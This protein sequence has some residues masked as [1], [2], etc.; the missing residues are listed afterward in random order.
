M[1][2]TCILLL[3][4]SIAACGGKGDGTA[5]DKVDPTVNLRR[6]QLATET[7]PE[8]FKVRFETTA[9]TF[10]I[11]AVREWSPNGVDRFYNLAR[12]GFF[13]DVTF[14][15]VISGFMAQFGINGDPQVSSVWRPR[16][17]EDDPVKQSNLRGYVTFAKTGQPNSRSTQLF[18]NFADNIRLDGMGFSPIGKVVEGMDVVDRVYAGYGE[19]P[20]RGKGPNQSRVQRQGNLYLRQEFPKLD[21]IKKA[22]LID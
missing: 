10:V 21:Y 12:V 2:R 3:L 13:D 18:I 17:I 14:F 11:E 5:T 9:G 4:L 16:T 20:P 22:T 8:R 19:G 6:P 7:A 1:S 15:R